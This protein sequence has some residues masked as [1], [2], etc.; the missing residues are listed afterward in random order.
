MA[1]PIEFLEQRAPSDPREPLKWDRLA[2][3]VGCRHRVFCASMA[4]VFDNQ[5]DPTI[6]DRLWRLIR[7]TQ[8]LDWLLLTKRIGNAPRM[9]GGPAKATTKARSR[10]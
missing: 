5:V 3:T 8:Y 1:R 9:L 4:D 6:R 2:G 10:G 7:R